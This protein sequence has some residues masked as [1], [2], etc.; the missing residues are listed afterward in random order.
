MRYQDQFMQLCQMA[1]YFSAPDGLT[2]KSGRHL[3][4]FAQLI[5]VDWHCLSEKT[6]PDQLR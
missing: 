3:V 6:H 4:D 5:A 1:E 2:K